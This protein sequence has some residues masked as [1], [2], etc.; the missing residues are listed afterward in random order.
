MSVPAKCA[1]NVTAGETLLIDDHSHRVLEVK[2]NKKK[3]VAFILTEQSGLGTQRW[4]GFPER[5][6]LEF[7]P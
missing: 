4:Y 5:E 1:A 3:G 7:I 2:H 6:V